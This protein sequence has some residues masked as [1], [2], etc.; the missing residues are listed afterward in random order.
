M[1]LRL[2]HLLPSRYY[3]HAHDRPPQIGNCYSHPEAREFQRAIDGEDGKSWALPLPEVDTSKGYQPL[4][5]GD[6]A[7]RREAAARVIDNGKK[8]NSLYILT[9]IVDTVKH[10]LFLPFV[11][12]CWEKQNWLRRCHVC[13]L[14]LI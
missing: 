1:L 4:N 11:N 8:K 10:G 2:L 6:D 14:L 12:D 13:I 9:Y 5:K 3:T 7:A